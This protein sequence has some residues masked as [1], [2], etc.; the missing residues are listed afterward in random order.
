[1]SINASLVV[2]HRG[3][4]WEACCQVISMFG[5]PYSWY[6]SYQLHLTLY[7]KPLPCPLC[8]LC[9]LDLLLRRRLG[10]Y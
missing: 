6:I 10:H 1:M 2:K 7:E 8:P 9:L 3:S 4:L 5:H